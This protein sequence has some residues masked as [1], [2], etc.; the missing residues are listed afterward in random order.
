MQRFSI[1]LFI[2]QLTLDAVFSTILALIDHSMESRWWRF[3]LLCFH[4]LWFRRFAFPRRLLD[5]Y[6]FRMLPHHHYT[7]INT[8]VGNLAHDILH[9]SECNL[10]IF[11]C[12][13]TGVWLSPKCEEPWLVAIPRSNTWSTIEQESRTFA[14]KNQS[15][16]F[17][18]SSKL[19]WKV[20]RLLMISIKISSA[21]RLKSSLGISHRFA[22]YPHQRN[23]TS[24]PD[25]ST[26]DIGG[27]RP[28]LEPYRHHGVVNCR[29]PWDGYFSRTSLSILA[30]FLVKF[31]M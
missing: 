13:C 5:L 28:R 3:H 6:Q 15:R 1:L 4:L 24:Y 12:R 31:V 7:V 18:E 11:T 10:T 9:Q 25:H 29:S 21:I 2:D 27:E 14:G 19:N 20:N 30:D 17:K 26:N 23:P 8:P 16:S 22:G